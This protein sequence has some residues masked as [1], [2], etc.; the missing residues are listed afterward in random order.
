M[1][2]VMV[3]GAGFSDNHPLPNFDLV[4]S[5]KTNPQQQPTLQK[6]GGVNVNET[7]CPPNYPEGAPRKI[8]GHVAFAEL[9]AEQAY[10]Q[11]LAYAATGDARYAEESL[12]I[13]LAWATTNRVWG[14]KHKNGPLEAAW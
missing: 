10:K 3:G 11:A 14:V 12:K 7:N 5:M 9:D 13:M 4:L 6:Q 2:R 8:C 1:V